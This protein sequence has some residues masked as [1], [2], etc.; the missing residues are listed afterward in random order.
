MCD[1]TACDKKDT[2]YRFKATPTPHWQSYFSKSPIENG[3]CDY[4][5]KIKDV[6][7]K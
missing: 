7:K 1:G 4:F 3:E 6:V 5:T 2:C